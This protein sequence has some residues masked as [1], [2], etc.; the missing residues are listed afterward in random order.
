MGDMET[1]QSFGGRRM[2]IICVL[3]MAMQLLPAGMVVAQSSSTPTRIVPDAVW[4]KI[5][6]ESVDKLTKRLGFKPLRAAVIKPGNLEVRIWTGFG[7]SGMGGTIIQRVGDKWSAVTLSDPQ[8][9]RM[10][11]GKRVKPSSN[12]APDTIDWAQTWEKL[13]YAGIENI[14]DD[15]EIPHCGAILDGVSYVV[16]IAKE[17]SY[18]TYMVANPQ[19]QRSEDGDRFLHVI[20]IIQEAF[21]G[22]PADDP[23][24]LQSGE[25]RVVASFSS[26]T[27]VAVEPLGLKSDGSEYKIGTIPPEDS[28]VHLTP[29]EGLAQALDIYAPQCQDF[30]IPQRYF[31]FTGD[32]FME[33]YIQPDGKVAAAKALRGHSALAVRTLEAALKWKFMPIADGNKIRQTEFSVRYKEAWVRFPWI[34]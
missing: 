8:G 11:N 15:S 7:I 1:R 34:K 6:F 21:G 29:E 12:K 3:F 22:I 9:T 10:I 28:I 18:R 4:V 31:R 19:L 20:S 16:E 13:E 2:K 26:D 5:F 24:K 32:V 30:P 14:R 25:V 27:L 17:K 23:A 33:V